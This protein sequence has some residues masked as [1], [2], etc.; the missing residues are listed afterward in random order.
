MCTVYNFVRSIISI[1]INYII[2]IIIELIGH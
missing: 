1:A 2:I